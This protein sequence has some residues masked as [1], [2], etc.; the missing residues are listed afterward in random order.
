MIL[1][2]SPDFPSGKP[3][4]LFLK[5]TFFLTALVTRTAVQGFGG[6]ILLE[7]SHNE[8]FSKIIMFN[9]NFN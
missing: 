7:R 1:E 8:I 3:P 5:H 4:G 6:F 9:Q 2:I